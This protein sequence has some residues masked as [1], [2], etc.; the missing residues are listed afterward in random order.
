MSKELVEH[1]RTLWRQYD[2]YF[3]HKENL[4]HAIIVIEMA[5]VASLVV[6]V[7]PRWYLDWHKSWTNQQK[8]SLI[9]YLPALCLFMF[10]FLTLFMPHQ[11]VLM[12][13]RMRRVAAGLFSS[14][15]FDDGF[16]IPGG[17]D[18]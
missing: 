12:Q 7:P 16:E 6:T 14:L 8:D 3:R 9:F 2:D 1:L 5:V 4:C 17:A 11:L 10:V 15:I 13:L 18:V